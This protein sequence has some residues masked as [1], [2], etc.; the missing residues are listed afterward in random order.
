MAYSIISSP[1]G[2]IKLQEKNGEITSIQFS[3]EA[4]VKSETPTL[5]S[6]ETQL[7]EYFSGER[8][9]FDFPINFISG[10]EFQKRVW[11]ELKKIPYGETRSYKQIAQAI[12]ANG[13]ARAVGSANNKNPILIAI[14]CH[15]VIGVKGAMTGYAGG[16]NIKE[17]LLKIEGVI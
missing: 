12:G 13:A 10:T 1:L 2:N 15:R 11:N 6:A 5:Q 7:L 17:K 14:P 8:K 3:D 4:V 9:F 16:I